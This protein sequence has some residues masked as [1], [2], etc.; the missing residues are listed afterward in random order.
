MEEKKKRSKGLKVAK[1]SAE[2]A[3]VCVCVCVC[4]RVCERDVGADGSGR[5][6]F[7]P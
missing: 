3:L 2:V 6:I 7:G 4:V 1:Y 5:W